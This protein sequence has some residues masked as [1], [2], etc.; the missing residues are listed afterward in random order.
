MKTNHNLDAEELVA[1]NPEVKEV[2]NQKMLMTSAGLLILSGGLFYASFNES[3]NSSSLSM[4]L[5]CLAIAMLVY[6]L[7]LVLNKRTNLMYQPTQSL[8]HRGITFF[9]RS[10]MEPVKKAILNNN[11]DYLCKL[12][13]AKSGNARI[14]FLHSADGNFAALQ[15]FEYIP[16]TFEATTEVICVTGKEAQAMNLFLTNNHE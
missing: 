9:D 16:Y 11:T 14:D 10:E 2:T 7:Y 5:L 8:I 15:L 4:A 12:K 3:E 13:V 6:A 1:S